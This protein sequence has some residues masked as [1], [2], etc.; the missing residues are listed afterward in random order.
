MYRCNVSFESQNYTKFK[1]IGV[2]DSTVAICTKGLHYVRFRKYTV[3]D[4]FSKNSPRKQKNH[5]KTYSVTGKVFRSVDS[6]EM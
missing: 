5:E 1:G 4:R 3:G 2:V 6:F